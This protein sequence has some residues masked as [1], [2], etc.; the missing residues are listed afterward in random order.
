MS[1]RSEYQ[2]I[3]Y[4]AN[5]ERLLA[6]A[7]LY[8]EA[9]REEL[10]VNA[11]QFRESRQYHPCVDCGITVKSKAL[12]CKSCAAKKSNKRFRKNPT[13]IDCGKLITRARG[14]RCKRCATK[15]SRGS[16]WVDDKRFIAQTGYMMVRD[17]ISR[18]KNSW[19]YVGEHIVVWEMVHNKRLPKG[20]HVHHLNGIKTDNRPSNL[21]AFS[22]FKHALVLASK[23]KR[24]QEL[25]GLL[26][27]QGQLI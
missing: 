12:R 22:S 26:A 2:G 18:H 6:R 16:T 17:P 15:A 1:N 13:C 21:V 9:H 27:K 8:R 23:A 20:W 14:Q 5:R 24:I 4:Q 19:G 11:A 3:Y 10:R 7:A 25:E